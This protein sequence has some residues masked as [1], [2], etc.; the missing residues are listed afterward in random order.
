MCL[1]LVA[2]PI[3]REAHSPLGVHL[4]TSLWGARA[5]V[6]TSRQRSSDQRQ[7]GTG[8]CG[9]SPS[10]RKSVQEGEVTCPIP[11]CSRAMVD[12]QAACMREPRL[13]H[14]SWDTCQPEERHMYAEM[15]TRAGV[16]TPQQRP[17]GLRGQL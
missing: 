3:P 2:L 12:M 17:A 1:F 16:G 9:K 5:R 13:L 10:R 4:E 14:S 8:G 7:R 6:P 11:P 15:G